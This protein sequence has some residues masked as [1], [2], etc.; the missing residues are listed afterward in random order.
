M[1][2]DRLRRSVLASIAALIALLVGALAAP[3]TAQAANLGCS[4]ASV[5]GINLNYSPATA[6]PLTAS[7][8]VTITCNKNGNNTD[9][10][11]LELGANAGLNASGTQNRA[12]NGT[13]LLS[14]SLRR[15]AALTAAWA[16]TSGNR[17]TA[18]VNA[19]TTTTLT[20]NWWLVAAAGQLVSA[21]T[22]VDTVTLS[23]YQD[24][25][26]NPALTD[27]T[28]QTATL[29]IALTVTSQCGLSS[30]PGPVAFQ[31]TSFQTTAA[32]AVSSFAVTCTLG[33]PYTVSLDATSGTMLG[34]SY[35]LALSPTGPRTGTGLAQAMS[36][37]GTIPAGQSG[38]CA[39]ASCTATQVRTL[40][41]SY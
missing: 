19:N 32:T 22:H 2:L 20:L 14:Y 23:L 18:S 4:I 1:K 25:K 6:T 28:P 29:S 31:Y 38:T 34:L 36:V 9:I 27:P 7:G 16:D 26:P 17:L 3:R 35:Q 39:A 12:V 5:S 33:A 37:T 24:N 10:R 13:S 11:Y 8:T 41:I 15:D 40:T 21:G 30:T